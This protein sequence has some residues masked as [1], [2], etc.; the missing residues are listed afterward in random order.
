M[1]KVVAIVITAAMTVPLLNGCTAVVDEPVGST[2]ETTVI[3]GSSI[4]KDS[5]LRRSSTAMSLM[6]MLSILNLLMT[7]SKR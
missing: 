1:K 7:R 4:R 2:T 3:S 5:I 6:T